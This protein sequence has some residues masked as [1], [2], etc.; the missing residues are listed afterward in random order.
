MEVEERPATQEPDFSRD[1]RIALVVTAALVGFTGSLRD[2]RRAL[3]AA[4]QVGW[5]MVA[6]PRDLERLAESLDR[7]RRRQGEAAA[8]RLMQRIRE[9]Y[10]KQHPQQDRKGSRRRRTQRN[11]ATRRPTSRSSPGS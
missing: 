5:S 1:E 8:D 11:G 4:E 2:H 3:D 9:Q 10:A 6:K 7:Q